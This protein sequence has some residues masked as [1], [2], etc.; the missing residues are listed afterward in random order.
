MNNKINLS[1]SPRQAKSLIDVLSV[2]PERFHRDVGKTL[3][4]LKL[5]MSKSASRSQELKN[6]ERA[7]E[8]L[9]TAIDSV[10]EVYSRHIK[11]NGLTLSAIKFVQSLENA[12]KSAQNRQ[13]KSGL[14]VGD[15]NFEKT[16]IT[17]LARRME[18]ISNELSSGKAVPLQLSN[19]F[20]QAKG[21]QRASKQA[22]VASIEVLMSL[23]DFVS[24]AASLEYLRNGSSS[25]LS[26]LRVSKA[27]LDG[28]SPVISRALNTIYGGYEYE[29]LPQSF[30]K[31]VE[32]LPEKLKI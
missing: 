22:A 21:R 25:T 32:T 11:K 15:D 18:A 9:N 29:A 19:V 13:E 30:H 28:Y 5:A 7:D 10:I 16:V 24:P 17:P 31:F 20:P 6:T 3:S 23:T 12:L 14:R 27:L 26:M 1:L 4:D 2:S 8:V